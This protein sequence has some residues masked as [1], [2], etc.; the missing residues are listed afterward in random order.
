MPDASDVSLGIP[1]M[2]DYLLLASITTAIIHMV[3]PTQHYSTTTA[4]HILVFTHH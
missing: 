1:Q 2:R 3:V 4:I